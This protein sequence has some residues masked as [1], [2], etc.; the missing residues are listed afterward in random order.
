MG[1]KKST[2]EEMQRLAKSRQGKCLSHEYI[3][4][5]TKLKWKC[6]KGHIW[7]STPSTIKSG[8]WC[9][10]CSRKKKLTI[11]EMQ[12]VALERGGKCLSKKYINT[13]TKLKWQCHLLHTWEAEPNSIKRGT[14]CPVCAGVKKPTIEEMRDLAESKGGR[15]LSRKYVNAHTKL[16]WKCHKG[17][18]WETTSY[19][20]STIPIAFGSGPTLLMVMNLYI[21]QSPIYI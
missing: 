14:W 19:S 8:H 18:I 17:H 1:V 9:A 21:I 12:E 6:H 3:N 13:H 20:F 2:I 10:K 5:R 7:F 11:E 15:C 4:N 16:K